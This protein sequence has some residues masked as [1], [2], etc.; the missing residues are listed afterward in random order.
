MFDADRMLDSAAR[1]S[2][3]EDC[4]DAEMRSRFSAMV[5]RFN[6]NGSVPA[7][8]RA[9]AESD[10]QKLLTHRLM[11]ERD[12]RR[13]PQIGQERIEQ[14]IFIIGN[15]RTGTT[16]LQC[17]LGEDKNN[18]I[19]RYW[20]AHFPSP[21][22]G[23]D[24]DS[25]AARV[26]ATDALVKELIALMPVMLPCHPYLDQGGMAELE[27]E[28]IF[29]LDF[30][31]TFPFQFL[32]VPTVP[33]GSVP[34]NA[35]GAFQ[36][37]KR[38]LQY[39]QWRNAPKRWV[40]KG[41]NHQFNLEALWETYPDAI[42]VWPHRDPAE[43]LGSVLEMVS[44]LYGPLT[45]RD[46]RALAREFVPEIK[47]GY[48]YLLSSRLIDHPRL[49][50]V[51]FPSLMADQ[52]GTIRAIY[53]RFGIPFSA[54]FTGAIQAWLSDPA[55]FSNR[56]GRFHYALEDFGHSRSDI[57]KMFANYCERFQL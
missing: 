19:L 21:P 28:D 32:H 43:F 13:F 53:E 31:S 23:A 8:K 10:F 16:I 38:M 44:I 46:C 27:D 15:P 35:R 18:R 42:C 49:V 25:I 33:I 22:P 5:A 24:P 47:A 40:C 26:A 50:H 37:H 48:D 34:V 52:V 29:T 14:P 30:E 12:F 41:P 9:A 7:D 17:L 2:S 6:A 3:L 57:K 11:I 20:Q 4:V 1:E 45:G 36:F 51:K 56:H 55:H 39:F 54:E